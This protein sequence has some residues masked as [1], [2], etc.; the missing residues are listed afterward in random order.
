MSLPESAAQHLSGDAIHNIN[1]WL[2]QPKYG[3]YKPE[4]MQL[5]ADK[6]WQL[7]EDSFFTVIEF[8]TSGRR[9]TTGVGSNRINSVTIGE[10]AQALCQYVLDHDPSAAQSGIVIACDTRL[11][12][13]NLS[14]IAAQVCAG[15]GFKTYV[16]ESFRSTPQ[17]S[18]AVRHVGAAAGIVISASHNPPQDNGFKAYWSDG[19]QVA[20]PHD[21]GILKKALAIDTILSVDYDDA[22]S[23]G[24]IK[25]LGPDVDEAYIQTVVSQ[26]EGADRELNIVY[27]PLHGAGQTNVLPTLKAAG[28]SSVS[29]VNEQM[30]PDGNFPTVAHFK[31]NPQERAANDL[32]VKQ[33]LSE[34]AD[35]AITNDPDADRFGVM[36]RTVDD[37]KYLNGNE[38][39]ILATDYV[40]SKRRQANDLTPRHYVARTIVTT[41][42]ID[43]LAAHYDVRCYNNLLVGFKYF[44]QLIR[45][46]ENSD[47]VYVIGGEESY[48][49][50]KGTYA[51]DKDGAVG[52]LLLAEYAAE[53]KKDNTTLQDRLL[54][55]Y[56]GHGLYG[57]KMTN[58]DFPGADGFQ[59]MKDIM[60]RLRTDPPQ[61]IGAHAVTAVL[62]YES[63]ERTHV[64]TGGKDKID[65]MRGN[66]VVL[67]LGDARRRIT[68]RPSGTEAKMKIYVQWY[69]VAERTDSRAIE[70]QCRRLETWMG[71]M[72]DELEKTL[73]GPSTNSI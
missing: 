15:N 51:R 10:S 41:G 60:R 50:L 37:V 63:L 43:A 25:I 49:L 9:G 48:G 13:P 12:S 69:D 57:D 6:Q 4:L 19:S 70:S 62:D 55:L 44:G 26:A 1:E 73:R 54:E 23:K 46:K 36:V 34:N 71:S 20:S 21:A 61:V 67:E 30:T 66:V 56:A 59:R 47:E 39:L 38:S 58:I 32:A 3:Q 29:V 5:I 2:T 24:I 65:S 28:F 27:S 22:V 35:I 68:V 64:A 33:M 7:L 45:E 16:F 53:L 14:R 31:P 72:A 18:F 52:A 17:L 42:M 8:G 40:L 11:S